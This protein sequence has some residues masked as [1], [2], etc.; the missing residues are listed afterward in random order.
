MINKLLKSLGLNHNPSSDNYVVYDTV[1][2]EKY[3][4]LYAGKVDFTEVKV[5]KIEGQ[6][7]FI[8]KKWYCS[9]G[10]YVSNSM[11]LCT[12]ESDSMTLELEAFQE[13]YIYYRQYPDMN[14]SE[15]QVI[16]LL[17]SKAIDGDNTGT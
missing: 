5:P 8:I 12:L 3:R 4:Q 7:N 15:G 10:D 16:C 2:V 9:N 17:L 13:G 1:K 6:N 11:K 14:L